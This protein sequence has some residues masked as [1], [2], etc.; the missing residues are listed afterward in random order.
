[1]TSNE[2]WLRRRLLESKALLVDRCRN[3]FSENRFDLENRRLLSD[4]GRHALQLAD[5]GSVHYVSAE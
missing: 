5:G 1:M 4:D 3:R 2:H